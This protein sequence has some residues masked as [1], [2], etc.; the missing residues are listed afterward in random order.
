MFGQVQ[1]VKETGLEQDP[2][3]EAD[4]L[5]AVT[6]PLDRADKSINR[7]VNR[8]KQGNAPDTAY[9]KMK[10]EERSRLV[11]AVK[12]GYTSFRERCMNDLPYF[13]QR[14]TGLDQDSRFFVPR[15][16]SKNKRENWDEAQLF[17]SK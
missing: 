10:K 4:Y 11:Q 5:E 17:T 6:G 2:N 14:F 15:P 13:W 3:E 8:L 16:G 9:T 7:L 1:F 12:A